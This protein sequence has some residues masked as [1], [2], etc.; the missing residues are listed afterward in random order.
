MSSS[1]N[2]KMQIK[3][4]ESKMKRLELQKHL[5]LD[6]LKRKEN[7]SQRIKQQNVNDAEAKKQHLGSI[8]ENPQIEDSRTFS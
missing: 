2:I 7:H 3:D 8:S 5:L 4:I 1:E 6:R